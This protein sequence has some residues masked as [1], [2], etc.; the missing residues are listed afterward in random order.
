MNID[1]HKLLF[2]EDIVNHGN[3][4]IYNDSN[5]NIS[6]ELYIMTVNNTRRAVINKSSSNY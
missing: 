6:Q 2:N 5:C 4:N 1:N 3:I